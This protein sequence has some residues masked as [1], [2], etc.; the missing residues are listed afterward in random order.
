MA[1]YF[2]IAGVQMEVVPEVDNADAALKLLKTVASHFPW[3]D[4]VLFSELGVHGLN[5]SFKEPIPNP[6]IE[7]FCGW[8]GRKRSGS[9]RVF[10]REGREESL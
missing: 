9:S 2:G 6:T 8:A 3:V 7:K 10:F 5:P 1:R 4:L